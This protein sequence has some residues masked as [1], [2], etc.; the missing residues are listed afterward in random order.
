MSLL[1][2]P[3]SPSFSPPLIPPLYPLPPSPLPLLS[4]IYFFL[5][6]FVLS[7]AFFSVNLDSFF[8]SS[9][10]PS[11]PL[12][13]FYF[14]LLPPIRLPPLLP[15]LSLVLIFSILPFLLSYCTPPFL[16]SLLSSTS[17]S[18]LFLLYHPSFPS[19][20]SLSFHLL[21]LSP[22]HF[23]FPATPILLPSPL[24]FPFVSPSLS[25]SSRLSFPCP[26]PSPHPFPLTFSPYLLSP[27]FFLSSTP[28]GYPFSPPLHPLPLSRN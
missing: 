19:L 9:L 23:C 7:S 6:L 15:V 14:L 1:V 24:L 28:L 3:L 21:S 10:F 18:S 11:S 2:L 25:S 26:L 4:L 5:F 17:F 16:S 20:L 22:F 8:L 12:F 13:P 27:L